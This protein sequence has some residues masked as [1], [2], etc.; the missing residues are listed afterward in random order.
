MPTKHVVMGQS[1]KW[2]IWWCYAPDCEEI[3][4]VNCSN[5]PRWPFKVEIRQWCGE[6]SSYAIIAIDARERK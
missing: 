5:H 2:H 1:M 3:D 4:I 6:K